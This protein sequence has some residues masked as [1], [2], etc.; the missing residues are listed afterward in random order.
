MHIII[1]IFLIGFIF[2]PTMFSSII[3]SGISIGAIWGSSKID[4]KT[5]AKIPLTPSIISLI[6]GLLLF[7]GSIYGSI[8]ISRIG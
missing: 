2:A 8:L 5:G 4:K 6:I 7:G 3:W 1:K